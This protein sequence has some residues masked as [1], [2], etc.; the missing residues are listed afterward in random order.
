MKVDKPKMPK[1]FIK[2]DEVLDILK[3][4]NLSCHLAKNSAELISRMVI[5]AIHDVFKSRKTTHYNLD[6][7]Q[8]IFFVNSAYSIAHEFGLQVIENPKLLHINLTKFHTNTRYFVNQSNQTIKI[9]DHD[10]LL[11]LCAI[12]EFAVG[13]LLEVASKW[14]DNGWEDGKLTLFSIRSAVFS[15]KELYKLF[16]M[17]FT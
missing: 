12:V 17:F 13:D 2:Y 6:S 9:D 11:Y 4:L 16:N 5:S 1:N 10:G 7:L 14:T 3:A 8:H 15:D